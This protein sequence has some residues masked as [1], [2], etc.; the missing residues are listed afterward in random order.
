MAS[1]P[2][3]THEWGKTQFFFDLRWKQKFRVE[4][5]ICN[6]MSAKKKET[7]SEMIVDFCCAVCVV[8]ELVNWPWT[9]LSWK[10]LKWNELQEVKTF[11]SKK[12]KKKLTL[13]VKRFLF[14]VPLW[15][16]F[17]R[18]WSALVVVSYSHKKSGIKLGIKNVSWL[19]SI[20]LSFFLNKY[21][22]ERNWIKKMI[23]NIL[24]MI[25]DEI[26]R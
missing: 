17:I 19:K 6:V 5:L 9:F 15:L 10:S 1:E 3:T 14:F 16:L 4:S 8:Y 13:I 25:I 20:S 11:Y 18:H 22:M 2:Q 21:R 24:A 23:I 12:K 26:L 7:K